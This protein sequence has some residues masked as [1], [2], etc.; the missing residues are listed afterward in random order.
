MILWALGGLAVSVMAMAS[1]EPSKAMEALDEGEAIGDFPLQARYTDLEDGGFSLEVL[2][3][4][5]WADSWTAGLLFDD[6]G[7]GLEPP[8][9]TVALEA[10]KEGEPHLLR[11]LFDERD[12]SEIAVVVFSDRGW[13]AVPAEW[14]DAGFRESTAASTTLRDRR[15]GQPALPLQKISLLRLVPP[16]KRSG[17]MGRQRFEAIDTS[18]AIQSV[19]F[20]VEGRLAAEDRRAPFKARL[21]LGDSVRRVEVTVVG[22][23]A[24]G[25][26]I[27][28]DSLMINDDVLPIL[29]I[30]DV[31]VESR[32]LGLNLGLQ[33][34]DSTKVRSLK[35]FFGELEL[36]NQEGWVGKM[37]WLLPREPS[38]SDYI[39]VVATLENTSEIEAV[40]MVLGS[41]GEE[42]D[43]NLVEVFAVVLDDRGEPMEG[44]SQA[45]FQ[46]E[47]RGRK[48]AIEQFEESTNR[49][50]ALG[51]VVD[52]SGSMW[53]LL[54]DTK[55][56]AAQ[57]IDE[58]LTPVDEGFLV[59][60]DTRPRLASAMTS[61]PIELLRSLANLK[62][63]GY[64]A[65]FDSVVFSSLQFEKGP[66]R[67]ALVILTDGDDYRSKMNIRQAVKQAKAQGV[68]IYLI[69]LAGLQNERAAGPIMNLDA[70]AEE[71][72]G[73]VFYI[74]ELSQ[75]KTAYG[76][77]ARELRHQYYLGFSLDQPMTAKDKDK[78]DLEVQRAEEIR[79]VVAPSE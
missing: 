48:V 41:F 79:A 29:K 64:T 23:D 72:G 33:N 2:F 59:D 36:L 61:N 25:R 22:L 12:F 66:H 63:E 57:F 43:V 8:W 11:V 58:V 26:E 46:L 19:Q 40:Q 50:L 68:P 69:G 45:D 30:R 39:R 65:L 15:I 18:G 34:Y 35:L 7:S 27:A 31:S 1:D 17:I 54:P 52:T 14:S 53:T 38:I 75:L 49:P 70:L 21:E 71:T 42:V 74:R 77:I 67:R 28:R 55:R 16:P 73:K 3:H 47:F 62:A 60:F 6:R 56:A 78:V 37:E 20:L 10:P 4:V 51:L 13:A 32:V 44:L 76:R 24:Q 9:E 5:P